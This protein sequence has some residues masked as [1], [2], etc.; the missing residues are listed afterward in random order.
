VKLAAIDPR[1]DGVRIA[2][3]TDVHCGVMTP[4][5][6]VRAAVDLV[7]AARADLVVMTGDYVCWHPREVRVMEEQLAGIEAPSVMV[8]LGNHDY[9]ASGLGVAAAMA[10]NGYTVLRNEHRTLELGGAPLH[11]I[12]IDD[13]VTRRHDLDRAFAQVPA[14]GTR[15]V[16]CHCPEQVEKIAA[17]G[18]HLVLSGHT[19]GGQINLRGI[20]DRV[21]RRMGRRYKGG[22]YGVQDCLLYVSAGV[23]FSG[24]RIRVGQGTRAEVS[25][26]TLRSAASAAA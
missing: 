6:H 15:L 2:H 18:A 10:Q 21:L 3:I 5:D 7:N 17:R 16:L 19:H 8:T 4:R 12:G 26:L 11:V 25:L 23:G 22:F 20:T 9:Y 24:V 13:P 1:H 14:G